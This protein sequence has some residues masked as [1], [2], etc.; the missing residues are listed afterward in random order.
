MDKELDKL[1]KENAPMPE[2]LPLFKQAYYIAS[3]GLY[4]QYAKR[5]ITLAQ[6]RLEKK[7]LIKCYEASEL[8]WEHMIQLHDL[9][10]Q[11]KQLK[12][13]GFNSVLEFEIMEKIETI[14][15]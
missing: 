3:R 12:E 10:Y 15:R 8:E 14:L 2:G 7:E 9:W 11:L 6:A 4:Q 13:E 1:A 5:E